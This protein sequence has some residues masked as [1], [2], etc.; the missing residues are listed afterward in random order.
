M[1]ITGLKAPGLN[2]TKIVKTHRCGFSLPLKGLA[3]EV[4]RVP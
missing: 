1:D 4:H 2:I 3:K